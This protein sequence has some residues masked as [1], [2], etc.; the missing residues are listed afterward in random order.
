MVIWFIYQS[1]LT[2]LKTKKKLSDGLIGERDISAC[3]S[4]E[5]RV[6]HLHSAIGVLIVFLND[7]HICERTNKVNDEDPGLYAL[8]LGLAQVLPMHAKQ[9]EVGSFISRDDNKIKI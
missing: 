4:G 1:K 9:H 8:L 5:G 7:L 6:V 2:N 3:A